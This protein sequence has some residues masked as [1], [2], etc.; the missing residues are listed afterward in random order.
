MS[1]KQKNKE[2]Q[3]RLFRMK[4]KKYF[5]PWVF[6]FFE[7]GQSFLNKMITPINFSSWWLNM[8]VATPRVCYGIYY[9]FLMS[10]YMKTQEITIFSKLMHE[11][12][13]CIP[14]DFKWIAFLTKLGHIIEGFSWALGL[15]T[16]FAALGLLWTC[17]PLF[18]K[19]NHDLS[20]LGLILTCL[21]VLWCGSGRY[22]VDFWILKIP[23]LK[24]YFL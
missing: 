4:S 18:L 21:L 20:I 17:I 13:D 16:R 12:F 24:K 9:P 23:F 3:V 14:P 10:Q 7:W 19:S 22:G 1:K 2:A 6:T 11:Y 5:P 8:F 15:N